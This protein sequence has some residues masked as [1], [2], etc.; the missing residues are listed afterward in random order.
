M[1][2]FISIIF[3]NPSVTCCSQNQISV[4]INFERIVHFFANANTYLIT[5]SI[6]PATYYISAVLRLAWLLQLA[7]G[8]GQWPAQGITLSLQRQKEF[9]DAWTTTLS[10]A[11]SQSKLM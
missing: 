6:I 9:S 4:L 2:S 8:P 5:A 1:L 3:L 10:Q 7:A 11:C